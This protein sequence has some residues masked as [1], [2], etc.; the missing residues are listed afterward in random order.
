MVT[1][2]S[3]IDMVQEVEGNLKTPEIRVWCHPHRIG[4]DGDDYYYIFDTFKEALDFIKKH[5][6]AEDAPL[7]AI[8]GYELN[9]LDLK[10]KRGGP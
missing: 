5:Q 4:K 3:T 2:P 10:P 6:E 9:L 7:L 8:A 1:V